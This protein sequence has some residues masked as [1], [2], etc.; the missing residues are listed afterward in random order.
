MIRFLLP[1]IAICAALF[2]AWSLSRN[3]EVRE[4]NEPPFAPPVSD[5]ANTIAGVGLIEPN[6]ESISL[7]TPLAGIVEKVF[8]KVGQAVPAGE[9]LFQI[10]VRH[11]EAELEI[12][13]AALITARARVASA[14]TALEDAVDQFK[15][16][17]RLEEGHTI[18]TDEFM[19]RQFAVKTAQA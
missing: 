14:Q 2:A 5:F 18:S 7:G 8:V 4:V 19:R 15:R 12:R 1:T 17:E 9:P 10:D 6:S 16:A 11:L 3:Q 13:R